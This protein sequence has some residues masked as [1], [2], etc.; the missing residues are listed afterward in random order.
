M[1]Q[2]FHFTCT[3][4]TSLLS[5]KINQILYLISLSST[6]FAVESEDDKRVPETNGQQ[7]NMICGTEKDKHKS[8]NHRTAGKASYA[9][10]KVL[11]KSTAVS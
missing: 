9:Y 6:G 11:N 5:L 8:K 7:R 2:V 4:H 10:S 1:K 3:S